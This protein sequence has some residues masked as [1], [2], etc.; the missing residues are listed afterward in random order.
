MRN[1][2]VE[3]QHDRKTLSSTRGEEFMSSYT[4]LERL[5]DPTRQ[6]APV[7]RPLSN[8]HTI[9]RLRTIQQELLA[10]LAVSSSGNKSTVCLYVSLT[11]GNDQSDTHRERL[12]DTVESC[13]MTQFSQFQS[14]RVSHAANCWGDDYIALLEVPRLERGAL[15]YSD[16]DI[17][18]LNKTL[19]AALRASG[20]PSEVRL[21]FAP[22]WGDADPS[23]ALLEAVGRARGMVS[24]L[25]DM[26][27]VQ[28][29][30]EFRRLM[31]ESGFTA[32]FQ[33]I[34]SFGSEAVLGWEAC[35]RGPMNSHFRYPSEAIAFAEEK[36]LLA[37]FEEVCW[38]AALGYAGDLGPDQKLFVN[39]NPRSIIEGKFLPDKACEAVERAGIRPQRIVIEITERHEIV[40]FEAFASAIRQTRERG[41]LIAIDD[42]GAGY[43]G[44]R[45][46]AELR[47]DFI[48]ADMSLVQG[49]H[50]DPA[51]CALMETFVTFAEKVGCGIIAEGIEEEKDLETL[52]NCGVHYGQGY[53]LSRPYCPK[54]VPTPD[55]WKTLAE[56]IT[57]TRGR[58]W[59]HKFLIG[60]IV[61]PALTVD[62]D[63]PVRIVKEL[64]DHHQELAGLVVARDGKVH[65]L[66]MRYQMDRCLATLYG[67]ELHFSKPIA[68]IMDAKP[69]I[70]DETA[71]LESAFHAA[72]G[73]DKTA[74][75]DLL[76]VTTGEHL[77]GVISMQTLFETMH[78]ER[79][80]VARG[81]NP[82][83][84]LPGNIVI[85]EQLIKR[86]AEGEPFS[87]I[88]VDLDHCKSYND[89]Y[90]FELG[91]RVI[92][93]TSKLLG[94]IL[95]KYGSG[96]D[97]LGHI[98]GDDF[99]AL[100]TPAC[101]E[102]VCR[103]A[104]KC[105][106]RLIKTFYSS[107]DRAGGG[108]FGH[109]RDGNEKKFP[110][111]SI[112]LG[113]LDVTD[114]GGFDVKTILK[115]LTQLKQYAKAIEGS[116]YVRD[117]RAE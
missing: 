77:K 34:I 109:D 25:I 2:M 64:L 111:I 90:G 102:E 53:L 13:F 11:A 61:E 92:L 58:P 73:R 35:V 89:H 39:V 52:I 44:L 20:L 99:F 1:D 17:V 70:F 42:V 75:N 46:I 88:Y 49:I 67:R 62:P 40:N 51:K 103:R 86:T 106:D 108:I 101:A 71:S 32:V 21:G 27:E 85:E 37:E 7:S 78:R 54:P 41:F 97:F 117:R 15:V 66:V 18:T 29:P 5:L 50:K 22:V 96:T 38:Q 105:F 83:T 80:E 16:R 63:T 19:V 57:A 6:Q 31:Q 94:S 28:L 100:T 33:P 79:V 23:T 116:V 24:S 87:V 26:Q 110:L 3:S 114:R 112:S 60:D 91:D 76:I 47:P 69:L 65:G 55:V 9:N 98:G 56:R 30:A 10:S 4:G 72:M 93:L 104:V 12:L 95:R 74:L 84:G 113:L 107:E 81:S 36:G 8:L 14:G 45:A 82:L 68:R 59:H 115:K 48:K 43:A